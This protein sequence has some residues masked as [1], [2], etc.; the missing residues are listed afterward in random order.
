[1]SVHMSLDGRGPVAPLGG[2]MDKSLRKAC[3]LGMVAFGWSGGTGLP[4]KH[5]FAS[6]RVVPM[7]VKGSLTTKVATLEGSEESCG[8][9]VTITLST[10]GK[11]PVT[12]P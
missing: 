3:W 8:P 6:I 11:I 12:G 7:I 9:V 10:N 2:L 5:T 1:M 4:E